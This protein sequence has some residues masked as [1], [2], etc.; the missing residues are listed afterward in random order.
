MN[1]LISLTKMTGIIGSGF[2]I[3]GYLPAVL[4]TE[5]KVALLLRSKEKF[6]SRKELQRYADRIVWYEDETQLLISV[7]TIVTCVPPLVQVAILDK[8]LDCSNIKN[9]IL[10]KPLAPSPGASEIILDRL[11]KTKKNFRIA[12]SFL[13]SGWLQ[14]LETLLKE[15]EH[16]GFTIRIIWKFE[17]H[18][19]RNSL[20]KWKRNISCGGGIIRFYGIH[21]IAV[22]VKL[23]F[24]GLSESIVHALSVDDYDAWNARFVDDRRNSV[25][26]D[27]NSN[28]KEECFKVVVNDGKRE[29]LVADCRSPF[30]ELEQLVNEL[31]PRIITLDKIYSDCKNIFLPL[32]IEKQYGDTNRLWR[33]IESKCI[34]R[35]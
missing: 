9:L 2:G 14:S 27:L 8:I 5:T 12:Y 18:H 22:L 25:E 32:Q 26:L 30:E 35:D 28:D 33:E 17:A 11:I 13:Y 20:Q 29:K 16:T 10:E 21:L 19:Y 15:N 1:L 31:D 6:E 3:Y 7:D 24:I 34:I 23:K 4:L